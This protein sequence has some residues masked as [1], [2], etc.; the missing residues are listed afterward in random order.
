MVATP[1]L[2]SIDGCVV[3]QG[4]GVG[5]GGIV[6]AG[7]CAVRSRVLPPGVCLWAGA[8]AFPPDGPVL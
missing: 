1:V 4:I 6:M 7:V 8:G 2:T 5:G 3:R